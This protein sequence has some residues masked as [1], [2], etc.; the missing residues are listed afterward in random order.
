MKSNSIADSS[1]L[2]EVLENPNLEQE[3]QEVFDFVKNITSE[4]G[5]IDEL[6]SEDIEIWNKRFDETLKKLIL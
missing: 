5:K 1:K 6:T 3:F 2:N 4:K